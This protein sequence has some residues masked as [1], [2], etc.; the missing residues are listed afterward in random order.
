MDNNV[1]FL[2]EVNPDDEARTFPAL[3]KKTIGNQVIVARDGSSCVKSVS[4]KL[5]RNRSSSSLRWRGKTAHRL[6][7]AVPHTIYSSKHRTPE[8]IDSDPDSSKMNP[9]LPEH[10]LARIS[11]SR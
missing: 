7:G 5:S 10:Y 2:V 8:F 3:K 6:S 4:R 1:I 9:P 11:S